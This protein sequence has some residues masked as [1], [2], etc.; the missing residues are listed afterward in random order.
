MKLFYSA[1]SPFVRKVMI[2]AIE[3][4]L[5]DRIEQIPAAVSPIQPNTDLARHNPLMKLPALITD[6]GLELIESKVI[7]QYLDSVGTGRLLAAGGPQRWRALRLEAIADGIADAGILLRYELTMRPEALRWPEWQAGQLSKMNNGLDLLEREVAAL[8]EPL[9]LGQVA[10]AAA[11]TWL[12]FRNVVPG[13]RASRPQLFAWLDR[14]NRE[15]ASFAQT[16]PR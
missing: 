15:R 10:V 2:V 14:M 8:D 13:A 1:A 11:C 9:H 3:K 16:T 6:D 7:C 12:E 4:G 5:A